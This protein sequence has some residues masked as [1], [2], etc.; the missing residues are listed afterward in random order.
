MRIQHNISALNASNRLKI[1]DNAISKNLQKL[2]S[3]YRI[4]NAAD[5]AAGLAISEKMRSQI[6]SLSQAENNAQDGISLV[7]TAE[8]AL[9]ETQSILQ[10]M[11]ELAQESANGTY[12]NGT[13][14]NNLQKEVDALKKEI[15]RISTST[16][17]NK[18][19]LLDGSLGTSSSTSTNGVTVELSN[20]AK[21]AGAYSFVEATKGTFTSAAVSALAASQAGAGITFKVDYT[22]ESGSAQSVTVSLTQ[23]T[24]NQYLI[25]SDGT[26]YT[27]ATTT[28]A[29]TAGDISTAILQELQ[30]TDLKNSF[31]MMV[32]GTY[33]IEFN[34]TKAGFD[35]AKVTGLTE[36][37]IDALTGTQT[38]K[39]Q[40][41][42]KKY[43]VD[44]Y[45]KTDITKLTMYDGTDATLDKA[46]FTVN[47]QKFLFANTA[48]DTS[49]LDS[50]INVISTSATQA[51]D[52]TATDAA[53]AS[54]LINQKTG[55]STDSSATYIQ[56]KASHSTSST[57][58]DGLVFQI[59]VGNAKDQ[60]VSLSI[61]NM[62]SSGLGI[63]NVSVATQEDSWKAMD[64]ISKAIDTVSGVRADL[65]ALQN[66]LEHTVN[67][68]TTAN[69]NLTSAESRIRD[70]DMSSEMV[71][72][73]K[74]QILEQAAT[75][76]LAQANTLPQNVLSLLK[77]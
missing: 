48:T 24:D 17:F 40:S 68:L 14:R 61:G 57:S 20:A 77:G 12:Q 36:T 31:S 21:A 65:G 9:S 35:G 46:I 26:K 42:T 1:N 59:G 56:Y 69:E 51:S 38:D 63:S 3:G 7:Q 43:G 73:T 22:D 15:D 44:A 11:N 28:A 62:S 54:R 71:S 34:A 74:N 32:T 13:D 45:E 6:N 2:S 58:T 50:S 39:T 23:S 41:V 67:N 70:V 53:N 49:K 60:R 8:G 18:I 4:N 76:M 16:N 33:Q 19:N 47:G 37:Q 29:A 66:R 55:L 64:T 25:A 5:D 75:S 52:L 10:R 72:L 30:K 27:I